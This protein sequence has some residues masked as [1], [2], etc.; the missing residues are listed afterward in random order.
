MLIN[1]KLMYPRQTVEAMRTSEKYDPG[2][3]ETVSKGLQ[4]RHPGDAWQRANANPLL[5]PLAH[6][7]L[8]LC[9]SIDHGME[10]VSRFA[11]VILA[12]SLPSS[13]QLVTSLQARTVD[14]FQAY[15]QRVENELQQRWSGQKLFLA[16]DDKAAVRARV[17]HGELWIASGNPNNPVPIYDGLVHDWVGAVFIPN[18]DMQKVLDVL[19]NFDRHPQIYPEVQ[20]SKLISREGN[21]IKGYWRLERQQV[22]T[23]VLDAIQDV[24]WR[25]LGPE[26]WV[27]RAYT[28]DIR[29]VE[30]PGTPQEHVLPAGQ[31]RGFLWRL[32]G[33]WSLEA[34]NGGV[35]AECRSLSL[36]RS[37]PIALS[38]VIKPFV[39]SLPR[40]TLTGTLEHTRAAAS[41]K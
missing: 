3:P 41:G 1:P 28:N 4:A 38:F 39:Q 18:T 35:L 15:A 31:G 17:M 2:L 34:T 33:Y 23:V 12:A 36:S 21:D 22:L 20:R 6:T 25:E 40:D 30:D 13:A 5:L 16:V 7:S 24:H 19:Q 37:I 14:E 9:V 10:M 11:C 32:Y 27:A 8:P 29:E 26:K